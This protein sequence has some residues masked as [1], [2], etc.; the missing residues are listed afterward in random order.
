M[1]T[2][3]EDEEKKQPD[4]R[5]DGNEAVVLQV[6]LATRILNARLCIQLSYGKYSTFWGEI[7]S[8]A[9]ENRP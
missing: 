8:P 9:G 6:D 4:R 2:S 7:Q 5:V 1:G 3:K